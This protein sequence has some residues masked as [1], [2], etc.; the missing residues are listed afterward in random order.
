MS[1]RRFV[2]AACAGGV[3]LVASSLAGTARTA[4]ASSGATDGG[5]GQ[6]RSQMERG[7]ARGS[8]P[9]C[10]RAADG[11]PGA[12]DRAHLDLRRMGCVR[13]ASGRDAPRRFT[14]PARARA[15][16]CEQG[17]RD[18]LRRL[19]RGRRPVSLE[20]SVRIRPVDG[21]PGLRPTDDKVRTQGGAIAG[22]WRV[23][24]PSGGLNRR[25]YRAFPRRL[26]PRIELSQ[27]S[28]SG[29]ITA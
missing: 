13:R 14:P 28:A 19:P 16:A 20:Q 6:R 11:L 9:I 10:A 21:E 26:H 25:F 15:L 24:P 1:R 2:R 17:G 4:P 23:K 22:S 18:Q 8:A 5:E 3:L 29:V 12:R 7:G 27:T